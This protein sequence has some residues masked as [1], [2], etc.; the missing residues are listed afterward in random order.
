M[1]RKNCG[2]WY[3]V[4]PTPVKGED[5]KNLVYV[6]PKS[7]QKLTMKELEEKCEDYNALRCGELSRAFDAFIRV[8]GRFLAEG[9]RIDTPIGSFAPKLSLAKQ[10]TDASMVKDRDVR[11]RRGFVVAR[12]CRIRVRWKSWGSLRFAKILRRHFLKLLRLLQQTRSCRSA[13]SVSPTGRLRRKWL[14]TA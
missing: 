13:K 14:T 2:M 7:G 10:G 12:F 8:A 3:E 6:R 11:L 1:P 9:Y 5:G 4:H